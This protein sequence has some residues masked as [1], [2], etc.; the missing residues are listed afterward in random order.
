MCVCDIYLWVLLQSDE[1]QWHIVFYIAS[2][3]YFVFNLFFVLFGK[4][5]IQ[6]W[7]DNDA[8]S[9]RVEPNMYTIIP[10]RMQAI[11]S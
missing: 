10:L 8:T 6:P 9:K 1:S 11:L 4:A 2:A 7:N 5:E 3:V